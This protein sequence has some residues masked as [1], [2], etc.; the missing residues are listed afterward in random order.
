MS[1]SFSDLC[2]GDTLGG[3]PGDEGGQLSEA[4]ILLNDQGDGKTESDLNSEQKK[5]QSVL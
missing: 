2:S 1:V 3:P 5:I 4:G